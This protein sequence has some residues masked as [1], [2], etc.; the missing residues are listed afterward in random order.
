VNT[1]PTRT[2]TA[3]RTINELT[4]LN[5]SASAIDS[6]IP[7]NTLTFSLISPPSGMTINTNTGA[8]SWSPTEAQGPSTNTITVIVTDDGSPNLSD[9][10]SFTVTVNGPPPFIQGIEVTNGMAILSCQTVPG[11]TYRLQCK[12][13][14]T[15]TNWTDLLPDVTATG[16]ITLLTNEVSASTQKFYRLLLVQ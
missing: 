8:I 3:E 14:F 15:E 12:G 10:K 16:S 5:L 11:Q 6:D 1:A 9:T 13:A 7:T 2:V 4:T